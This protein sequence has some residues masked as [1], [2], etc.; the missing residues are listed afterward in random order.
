MV[1]LT[2]NGG[3]TTNTLLRRY[4]VDEQLPVRYSARHAGRVYPIYAETMV[5]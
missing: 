5:R 2:A 3:H 4:I 1:M